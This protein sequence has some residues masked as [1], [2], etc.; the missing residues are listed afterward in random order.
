[1][2]GD[3]YLYDYIFRLELIN[4]KRIAITVKERAEIGEQ[5][6]PEMFEWSYENFKK[7]YGADI[8]EKTSSPVAMATPEDVDKIKKLLEVVKVEEDLVS[9]WLTKADCD[10]FEKFSKEQIEKCIAFLENKKGSV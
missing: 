8:L 2:K 3:D 5:K 7:F 9:K 6:F 1:M 10:S 4:G